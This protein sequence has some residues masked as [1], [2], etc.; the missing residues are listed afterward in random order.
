MNLQDFLSNMQKQLNIPDEFVQ[1]SDHPSLCRCDKCLNWW[2]T[3]GPDPDYNSC[4]PF[5]LDE[6]NA[7]RIKLGK[8]PFKTSDASHKA[9]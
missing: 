1:A 2:A 3:M 9:L 7:K 4:G 8:K 6:V 5:S